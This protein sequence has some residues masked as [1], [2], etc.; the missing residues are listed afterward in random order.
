[1]LMMTTMMTMIMIIMTCQKHR[2]V[3]VSCIF[4]NS[5]ATAALSMIQFLW[6][7]TSCWLVN[8]YWCLGGSYCLHLQGQGV[9]FLRLLDLEDKSTATLKNVGNY[10][11]N[12]TASLPGRPESLTLPIS[13]QG[14][15]GLGKKEEEGGRRTGGGGE[16]G[17]VGG[18]ELLTSITSTWIKL[19][20]SSE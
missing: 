3:S 9:L 20:R 1:M 4:V 7:V 15:G 2:C 8:S 11:P 17:G 12:N 6:D 18:G 19:G 13:G 14:D 5:H 16:E 10:S